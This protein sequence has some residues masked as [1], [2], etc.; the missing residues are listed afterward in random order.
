MTLM[1]LPGNGRGELR[2]LLKLL[3][4]AGLRATLSL[5]LLSLKAWRAFLEQQ[6]KK[7]GLDR[8]FAS[9]ARSPEDLHPEAKV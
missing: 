1:K 9:K 2:A 8:L 7:L 6:P 4:L 5:Q 3:F